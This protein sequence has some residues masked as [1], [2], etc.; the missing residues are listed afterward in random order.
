MDRASWSEPP[1]QIRDLDEIVEG[2]PW[3]DT[4]A[5][6]WLALGALAAAVG[7][8]AWSLSPIRDAAPLAMAGQFDEAY[9]HES[10]TGPLPPFDLDRAPAAAAEVEAEAPVRHAVLPLDDPSDPG[11]P[12]AAVELARLGAEP[13]E[14]LDVP[15]SADED[16][17]LEAV[18][19]PG[20]HILVASLRSK[21]RAELLAK[22]L[23]RKGHLARRQA[24]GLRSS[25]W[26]HTIRIGP[27]ESRVEAETYR[28]RFHSSETRGWEVRP[29]SNGR[30]HLQVASL[31]SREK[32]EELRE[33]L[34]R[35]GHRARRKLLSSRGRG[36][37][38][39]V[40]I[41][42]FDTRDE[43]DAYRT[44]FEQREERPAAVVPYEPRP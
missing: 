23:Q 41:G 21:Q 27:F 2:S 4:I 7:W 33:R 37:W 6:R 1:P 39:A 34:S 20:Y 8:G 12:T 13:D 26:W 14:A 40:R 3:W 24:V 38:H 22:R 36:A 17:P 25:G 31:R 16:A 44:A 28:L 10:P 11:A 18:D 15:I 9:R 29:R 19:D 43:A 42:P 32:A 5:W 30:F 35:R